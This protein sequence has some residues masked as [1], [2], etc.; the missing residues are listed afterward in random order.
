M[1]TSKFSF[2]KRLLSFK[3]A[4]NGLQYLIRKEPNFGIHLL[5]TILVITAGLYYNL[6]IIEWSI[7]LLTIVL[8][9]A[10]EIVNT[11]I[12]KIADFISPKKDDRIKII[13]DIAAAS[14]LVAAFISIIIGI[15]IFYPK[16][17][18]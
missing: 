6:A 2:K 10:L 13:K 11:V 17:Q 1:K 18:L 3:Y 9:L 5:A 8:V 16:M 15:F 4:F 12:E 7:L 14:V